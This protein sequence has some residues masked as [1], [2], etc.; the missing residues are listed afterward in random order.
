MEKAVFAF[1]MN[2]TPVE[3]YAFG[4]GHIN[5]TLK[6]TTDTGCEYVLQRINKYVF[7]DPVA[8]M[9]NAG[10]VTDYIRQSVED[11][12]AALHFLMTHEGTF[13]HEDENG[14]FWRMYDFV[15]GFCLDMPERD[16][17]F[18]QSALAFG[19]FQQMLC[20]FPAETLAETIPEFHNT[21]D[22]YK[23]FRSAVEADPIGRLTTC[24]EEVDFLLEREEKACRLQ[25]MR[26]SGEL[27]LRVTHNDT[28]LNNVLLDKT[29]RES[30][31]VLDL[32]TV[33]PGLSAYD[34]GDS[35]RFGA[36]TA[37]EDEKDL[38][39]ME[40]DLHMFEVYTKGFL[41][42]ATSLTDREVEMLPM[43]AYVM[44]VEVATRFL[45]DYLEGDLYFKTA[46]PDHNLVRAR[47][48]IKLAAD[49]EQK[50]AEMRAI[51]AHVAAEVRK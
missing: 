18:Y 32:D 40:M 31:C 48:Q 35:I 10:A 11:K 8:V 47:T 34:F 41:E 29:T 51:V 30:L 28:K 3:C 25:H 2:G 43:G 22:R 14:E 26:V 46:Y 9:R 38:S 21:I 37:A 49:M 27:P 42:A 23:N 16:E 5:D 33:M 15:G 7:K 6:V 17:D 13:C 45:K 24:Q 20:D 4:S 36:A 39:K 44:T 19:R 50:M 12:R 1:Q